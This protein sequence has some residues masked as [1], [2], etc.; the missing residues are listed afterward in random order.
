MRSVSSVEKVVVVSR[1]V[2]NV[3]VRSVGGKAMNIF[4]TRRLPCIPLR[5]SR[6]RELFCFAARVAASD[7]FVSTINAVDRDRPVLIENDE[8]V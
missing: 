2:Q 1:D 6:I 3:Y 8:G 7:E 5:G 4:F